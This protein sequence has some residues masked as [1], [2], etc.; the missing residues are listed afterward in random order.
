MTSLRLLLIGLFS[1][2]LSACPTKQVDNSPVS[3]F[4]RVPHKNLQI[5]NRIDLESLDTYRPFSIKKDSHR[6][7]V[8]DYARSN[9]FKIIDRSTL[10]V[11]QGVNYGNG[12][13]ELI[14]PTS[15]IKEKTG[16]T[17]YEIN[18]MKRYLI[19]EDSDSALYII[20]F[21][22]IG[23]EAVSLP[24]FHGS[25]M[26][27]KSWK[28]DSWIKYYKDGIEIDSYGFPDFP[29]TRDME[30]SV[31]V[32]AYKSGQHRFK[33]DGTR[34]AV[35]IDNGCALAIYD[36][37][38]KGINERI[39][40]NYFPPIFVR[41]KSD[42]SPTAVSMK[43][44]TGFVGLEC[45]DSFVYTLYAGKIVGDDVNKAWHGSHVFV[46]DWDGNPVAH[47]EL[48]KELFAFGVDEKEGL[49]YGIG[50][51]PEGC[52]LEYKF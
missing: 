5:S 1:V 27:A 23:V 8:F 28:G 10:Q 9:I 26:A 20:D 7:F 13:G 38:E 14:Y 31:L 29:E 21:Q 42:Y 11:R 43:C 25:Y 45:T 48:E 18:T 47:Y 51:D 16:M 44:R 37:D 49:L 50:Y 17:V 30:T 36:C 19:M 22:D 6:Y 39:L 24:D 52:I 32:D 35:V 41:T 2:L 4:R 46:Y 33:P 12:P 34:L 15:F 3:H 40:L